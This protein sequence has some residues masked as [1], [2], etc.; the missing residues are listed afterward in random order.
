MV[1]N[2]TEID[3]FC[4]LTKRHLF[5]IGWPR[6]TVVSWMGSSG[7]APLHTLTFPSSIPPSLHEHR[8]PYSTLQGVPRYGLLA[9]LSGGSGE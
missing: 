6:W 8:S 2:A 1:F 3:L 5:R 9:Q 7:D 4:E